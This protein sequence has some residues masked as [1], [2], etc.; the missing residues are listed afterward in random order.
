[1]TMLLVLRPEPGCSHTVDR[2]RVMGLDARACPLFVV[3][4][5]PHSWP[6]PTAFDAILITSANGARFGRDVL[7]CGAGLPIF[8]VGQASAAAAREQGADRVTTGPGDIAGT[9]PLILHAGHRR[10]LHLCGE[11]VMPFDPA[12]L[13]VT[14]CI[15]YRAAALPREALT[16]LPTEGEG[17]CILVHSF[18]AGRHLDEIIPKSQRSILSLVAI[19]GSV[20]S[21]C[22]EGWCGVHVSL[23][24]DDASMLALAARIC[25][26]DGENSETTSAI[27]RHP[28]SN[29][30]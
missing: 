6:D 21:A 11:D 26:Y 19:S 14:R 20:A 27:T 9:I 17:A 29:R 2:A 22:G 18:R 16:G 30:P 4:P 12:G 15:V 25:Q 8:A 1:M 7:A 5:M 10:I 23:Q 3:E 28:S 13:I 24:K